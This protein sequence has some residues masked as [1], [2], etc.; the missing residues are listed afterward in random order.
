MDAAAPLIVATSLG[1]AGEKVG[2]IAAA[3]LAAVAVLAVRPRLRAVGALGALVL[4]PVLLVGHIWDSPQVEPL[5]DHPIL[6]VAAVLA[7]LGAAG[8]L[9]L[10]M[11]RREAILPVL[12]VAA[13]PFRL[14]ITVGGETANLLIPLYL[15]VAAGTL[16]FAIPALRGAAPAGVSE[17][18]RG[19]RGRGL[20]AL[21][22]GAVVVYAVQATYS[23]DFSKALEQVVFFYVPFLLLFALLREVTWTR[24]VLAT[25]LG[26]AV[27]LA[28]LFVAVG[29][30]EYARKELFLNP[31][32]INAN[33][34]ESY[35]RVN[36]LFFDPN[37]YGRF[38]AL[39]M[40]A[41]C[42]AV[43]WARRG[44]DVLVGG[45]VLAVLWAGLVLSFSQSSFAAL[46]TGLAVL[47][48]LRWSV[49]WAVVASLAALAAGVAFIAVA[50]GAV[51]LELGSSRS[52]DK[53]TSGRYA[54]IKG[55]ARL[56]ADRPLQG[57]GAG[58]YAREYRQ[59]RHA[60]SARA[61]SA[62][63]TIPVTVAAEQGVIGLAVY[64]ALLAAALARLLPGARGSPARAAIAAAFASLVVHTLLYAA[65]LEDPLTWTLLG[66]GV[67][68][69]A[70]R[71]AP[72][73]AP[74]PAAA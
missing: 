15:A 65:F 8:A 63:H 30:V 70:G 54:L 39:V 34:F 14:P 9:A 29:F 42:A 51:H 18:R 19:L 49:R 2:A 47:G 68:L 36:S 48:G 32:V 61:V 55:G 7:A 67:A 3:L 45:V 37:I 24:R 22:A 40:L 46:L 10:A 58:A 60:S 69:A 66:V 44:R 31:K 4:T 26:V 56:F 35:F 25:C 13:L 17:A 12:A 53:A 73:G 64:L 62:S 28:L 5:R 71:A 74:R 23:S 6:A 52:A 57:Y 16:A 41:V 50:P 21:L 20:E 72:G 43:L 33:Q 38:L 59:R 11:R 1:H 27:A